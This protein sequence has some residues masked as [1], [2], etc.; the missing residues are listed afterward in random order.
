MN[1]KYLQLF[2]KQ[3]NLKKNLNYKKYDNIIDN[4]KILIFT[5]KRIS[6]FLQSHQP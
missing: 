2:I 6:T 4:I 3:V 1:K 5:C